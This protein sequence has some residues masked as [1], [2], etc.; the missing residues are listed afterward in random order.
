MLGV[1]PV[2]R[3]FARTCET[4]AESKTYTRPVSLGFD[5]TNRMPVPHVVPLT[6]PRSPEKKKTIMIEIDQYG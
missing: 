3:R 5:P 6:L 4:T 1:D 2:I